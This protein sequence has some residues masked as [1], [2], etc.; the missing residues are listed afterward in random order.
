MVA[1]VNA[2][3]IRIERCKRQKFDLIGGRWLPSGSFAAGH[4]FAEGNC[5]QIENTPSTLQK[6][7]NSQGERRKNSSDL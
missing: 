4:R 6:T 3:C 7:M 1:L 2:A 5:N